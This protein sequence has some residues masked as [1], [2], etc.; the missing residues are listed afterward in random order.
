MFVDHE[1]GFLRDHARE[2]SLVLPNRLGDAAR[3]VA[4]L[5]GNRDRKHEPD[6][7]HRITW[8]G[9]TRLSGAALGH[10]ISGPRPAENMR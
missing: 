1:P 8:H 9:P 6:P 3:L 4:C 5:G 10:R 7:G 2:Q